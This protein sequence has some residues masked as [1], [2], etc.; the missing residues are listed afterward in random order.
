MSNGKAA[1][2]LQLFQAGI[3]NFEA[4]QGERLETRAT[5]ERLSATFFWRACEAL[6]SDEAAGSR[7]GDGQLPAH[8]TARGGAAGGRLG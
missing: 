7:T 2:A 1:M 5:L 4:A 8:Q 6:R 3:D